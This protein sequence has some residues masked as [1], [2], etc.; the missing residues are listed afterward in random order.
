[1]KII[2]ALAMLSFATFAAI[3]VRAA[4]RGHQRARARGRA[5]ADVLLMM[6]T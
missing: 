2:I 1:M 4:V 5:G 3:P 6:L